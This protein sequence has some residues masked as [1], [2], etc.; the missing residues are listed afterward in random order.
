ML[1]IF[2]IFVVSSFVAF[3]E[4]ELPPVFQDFKEICTKAEKA[5]YSAT[6]Q[7]IFDKEADKFIKKWNG[8]E[9]VLL[10][11]VADIRENSKSDWHGPN[12][13]STIIESP[14]KLENKKPKP[15]YQIMVK[16]SQTNQFGQDFCPTWYYNENENVQWYC[17]EQFLYV[18]NEIDLTE[19][20]LLKMYKHLEVRGKILFTR[21]VPLKDDI[22]VVFK[23][24]N[25]YLII[26]D[27]KISLKE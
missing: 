14:T 5:E 4:Q 17:K 9:I 3:Q 21:T 12:F 1:Q 16:S 11:K 27:R 19:E 20:Q 15:K 24:R 22:E 8:K 13:R 6:K 7:I 18:Y 26:E 10:Q 25:L 23:H 2:S